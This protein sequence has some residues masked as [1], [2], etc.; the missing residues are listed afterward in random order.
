[1]TDRLGHCDYSVLPLR[2]GGEPSAHLLLQLVWT[3]CTHGSKTNYQTNFTIQSNR[4]SRHW[5][6]LTTLRLTS[7]KKKAVMALTWSCWWWRWLVITNV[8]QYEILKNLV[9]EVNFRGKASTLEEKLIMH[10][11]VCVY[12]CEI[13]KGEKCPLRKLYT[14]K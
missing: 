1:M 12:A 4:T 8:L 3:Y 13:C 7:E 5:K 11:S 14:T 2:Q 9:P 6:T 10:L